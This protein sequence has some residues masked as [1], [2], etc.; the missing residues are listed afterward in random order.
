MFLSVSQA[1]AGAFLNTVPSRPDLEVS[2]RL[3]EIAIQRRLGV[4]IALLEGKTFSKTLNKSVDLYGDVIQN[5]A[6]HTRRHNKVRDVWYRAIRAAYGSDVELEPRR[7]GAYSPDYRPDI[8]IKNGRSEGRHRIFEIKVGTPVGQA[9]QGRRHGQFT[10]FG[11]TDDFYRNKILGSINPKN[12]RPRGGNAD[13]ATALRL[14]HSVEP[15]IMEV[16]GGLTP[17]ACKLLRTL[18]HVHGAGLGAD[19]NAP[20]CAR[21]FKSIYTQRLSVALQRAAAEEL[22][23]TIRCDA[24]WNDSA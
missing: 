22:L 16:S 17:A 20:W 23:D 7:T 5:E 1:Y 2:S 4:Q 6:N 12:G 24:S 13:Y 10:A 19:T 8:Q 14:G 11:N 21:S 9:A 15:I 18:A 3:F